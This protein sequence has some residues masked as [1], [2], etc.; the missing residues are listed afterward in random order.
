MAIMAMGVLAV[1]VTQAMAA[2]PKAKPKAKPVK[3]TCKASV[4]TMPAAG[5]DSVLPPVQQGSQYGAVHCA[6]LLG[7]GVQAD[8]FTLL[9]TGDLQG[10][11]AQYFG[12]GTI[13]GTFALTADDTSPPSSTTTFASVSYTGTIKVTGGTGAFK[14]ATGQGTLKCASVDGVHFTC[15]ETVRV[16]VPAAS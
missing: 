15:N 14:K 10:K 3:V 5:E 2:K 8:S 9:D 6:K 1:G 13:H 12:V 7:S 4:G 16:T 11:Y